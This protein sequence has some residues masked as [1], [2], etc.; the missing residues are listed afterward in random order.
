[1]NNE[2]HKLPRG[3][4]CPIYCVTLFGFLLT[5]EDYIGSNGVHKLERKQI[6]ERERSVFRGRRPR[7]GFSDSFSSVDLEALE[8]E[9]GSPR[10]QGSETPSSRASTSDSE[11]QG[12]FAGTPNNNNQWR[13]FFKLLKKGSQMPF[14]TFHPL[15]N[16]PK[17]TRRKSKRIREDLIPSLN[18]ASLDTEFG[19]FKSSWKNFTLAEIQAATD[20]FS[21]ENLIG[22]GGYAEVY[23]GKLED[24]NFV[25]IKRLTRG[26]QEEMTA[27]FLSELGIIVHVDHPNIARLIGYGVEG[28]MF[29][30]LQLSPHGSLSSILYGPREK[31]NW[32]LRYKIAMGTAEG[33]RYLHEGCQ[34]RI[35]HKDIKA[36]NILLSEDF[37]PQISDFGLAKWLPDQWTHHTVSKVE[38]TFGYLPPEF[39]MH[40]IVDEKTDVYAY[41]VLLLEL[42]TGRQALDS[43]QKSLVMWAK[44]LLTA[45]NIKELVDPVLADAYDEEQMKLVTLTA[46]LCVDQSS[47]QR[48]VLDI[49]RG[50]EES[51]RIMKERSKSKLQR[52]YSEELLDA[53]EYNSTKFLSERDRH[54]ETILGCSSSVT[55]DEDKI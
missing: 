32:S 51:L 34:R 23:L 19:C 20:D 42:I 16:V 11:S 44:P 8:I 41:G 1:M 43:S 28:G 14:Q 50:E 55:E 7:P 21:H 4:A 27:D 9:E 22:E 13:G 3:H 38:G 25:A 5:K 36:S 37:E 47:I 30:V 29:L 6:A 18:A 54:M 10:S 49:L 33:L 45:N 52:T 35:I 40:G 17:L 31:L 46:S 2:N 39:F 53:E 24:G 12:S 26:C 48:P 15:K